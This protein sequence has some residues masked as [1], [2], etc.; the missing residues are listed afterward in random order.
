EGSR[1][2][3]SWPMRDGAGTAHGR[4]A[5]VTG[6]SKGIGAAIAALLGASGYDVTVTYH[7]DE[8]GGRSV[9]ARIRDAGGTARLVPLD[10]ADPESVA[11]AFDELDRRHGHL[12]LLVHNAV[13]EIAKPFDQTTL[14]EWHTMLG[15]ELDGAFLCTRCALPLFVRASQPSLVVISSYEAERPRPEHFAY[16]VTNAGVNAFVR[17]MALY[18]P[19]FGATCNA[20]CPGPVRTSL[21]G[22]DE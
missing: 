20:V 12:D 14:E 16:G 8:A 1:S 7:R 21:W 15:S 17:A 9:V 3:W 13:R 18:L 4:V 2:C 10:V 5:F 6:S 19:A 22:D 11:A